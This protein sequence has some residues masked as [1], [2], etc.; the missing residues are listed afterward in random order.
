MT[1]ILGRVVVT[2]TIFFRV[3]ENS[4]CNGDNMVV[5]SMRIIEVNELVVKLYY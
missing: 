3:Q 2:S 1:L 4:I 5:H